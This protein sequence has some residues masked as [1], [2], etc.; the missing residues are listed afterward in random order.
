MRV[1]INKEVQTDDGLC[2]Q[3]CTYHWDDREPTNGYRFIWRDERE[4]LMPS[5]GQAIIPDAATL[6]SLLA[7]AAEQ[8]W[9]S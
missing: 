6:L 2:F 8:K 7:K 4:N 5:R 3:H 1:Q 9:F